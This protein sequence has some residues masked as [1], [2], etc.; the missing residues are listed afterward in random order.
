MAKT[1]S[2]ADPSACCFFSS[3]WRAGAAE[4]RT[5]RLTTHAAPRGAAASS[6]PHLSR[7]A[8]PFVTPSARPSPRARVRAC[9]YCPWGLLPARPPALPP[10]A[11][12]HAPCSTAPPP[13]ARLQRAR[14]AAG[15][16]ACRLRVAVG[17]SRRVHSASREKGRSVASASTQSASCS[18][19][20]A[21][22]NSAPSAAFA[23]SSCCKSP[24]R[25]SSRSVRASGSR[26]L[27]SMPAKAR[28]GM[29]S[30]PVA[31][32]T[33]ARSSASPRRSGAACCTRR[34]ASAAPSRRAS[35]GSAPG[36]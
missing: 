36:T 5:R 2:I 28:G 13:R 20:A 14:K 22:A 17:R 4:A 27:H 15:G 23:S 1:V 21:A 8:H 31:R 11:M 6:P 29:A 32:R 7:A 16:C 9:A 18:D 33:A 25:C 34:A 10:P 30:R 12:Q 19:S 3:R 26:S 24:V 35:S